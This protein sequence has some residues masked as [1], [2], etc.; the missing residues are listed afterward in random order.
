MGKKTEL[1]RVTPGSK[2]GF[3]NCDRLWKWEVPDSVQHATTLGSFALLSP[4]TESKNPERQALLKKI[5]QA[6]RL[7]VT[8]AD[9][10]TT[11]QLAI[12][13]N[14][15]EAELRQVDQGQPSKRRPCSARKRRSASRSMTADHCGIGAFGMSAAKPTD[16]SPL[17]PK[18]P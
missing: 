5:E 12:M 16:E 8:T 13:L 1:A 6:R 7:L 17:D 15:L 3:I 14:E 2:Q 18:E 4:V 10:L 11:E 9:K